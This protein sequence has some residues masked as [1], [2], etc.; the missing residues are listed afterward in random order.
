MTDGREVEDQADTTVAQEARTEVVVGEIEEE[1]EGEATLGPTEEVCYLSYPQTFSLE[2][3]GQNVSIL[4]L[5]CRT[6]NIQISL[7][8]QTHALVL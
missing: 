1:E 3:R 7:V 5:S 4:H 2:F 6:S 8:M